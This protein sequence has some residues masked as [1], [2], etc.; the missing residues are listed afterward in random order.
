VSEAIDTAM[1]R[2]EMSAISDDDEAFEFA[3]KW[4]PLMCDEID[5]QR[6]RIA[7]LEQR[8]ESERKRAEAAERRAD[9]LAVRLATI[10]EAIPLGYGDSVQINSRFVIRG[11]GFDKLIAEIHG[12]QPTS[13]GS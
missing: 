5:A 2:A 8:A 3:D 11:E 7:E 12:E 6:Q 9:A 10:A 13:A 4:M 1:I